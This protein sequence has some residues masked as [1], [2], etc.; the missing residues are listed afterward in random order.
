MRG[1]VDLVA[2]VEGDRQS[3]GPRRPMVNW[4]LMNEFSCPQEIVK[5]SC[6]GVTAAAAKKLFPFKLDFPD[7]IDPQ[8][9]ITQIQ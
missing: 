2:L 5:L 1:R 7:L 4:S 9:W 6:A 8:D 3:A